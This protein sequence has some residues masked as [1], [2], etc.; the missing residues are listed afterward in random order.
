M[1]RVTPKIKSLSESLKQ[2]SEPKAVRQYA[3]ATSTLGTPADGF[4]HSAIDGRAPIVDLSKL[5]KA[6]L[7]IERLPFTGAELVEGETDD[8]YRP[9]FRDPA[10]PYDRIRYV[11]AVGYNNDSQGQRIILAEGGDYVE[12]TFYGTGLNILYT[13]LTGDDVRASINGENETGDLIPQSNTLGARNYSSNIVNPAFSGLTPGLHTVTLRHVSGTATIHGVEIINEAADLQIPASQLV[14]NG[15]KQTL[16]ALAT[17]SLDSFDLEEGTDSGQGGHVSVYMQNGQVKQAI[18]WGDSE[19][20]LGSTDHSEE[21]L[22]RRYGWR[23]FGAGRAD[24]F[25]TMVAAITTDRYFTLDDGTTTLV[26][27]D[28]QANADVSND[29]LMPVGGSGAKLEFTFVGTGFDIQNKRTDDPAFAEATYDVYVDDDQIASAVAA[30]TLFGAFDREYL[31][32]IVSGLPYG[33]HTVRIEINTNNS[34]IAIFGDLL[35]YAP[36][37]PTLPEDAVEI[38]SYYRPADYVAITTQSGGS[39]DSWAPTGVIRKMNTREFIYEGAS[40]SISSPSVANPSGAQIET[41]SSSDGVFRYT[42]F[43]TGF[44]LA[45]KTSTNRNQQIQVNLNGSAFTTANYG[46]PA[47]NATNTHSTGTIQGTAWDASTGQMSMDAST[48]AFGNFSA[49]GLP[50]DLYTIEFSQIDSANMSIEAFD[51]VTPIHSPRSDRLLN[52]D[53][54]VGSNGIQSEIS[55]PNFTKEKQHFP[56][57]VDLGSSKV[58]WQRRPMLTNPLSTNGVH[59]PLTFHNLEVGKTYRLNM[60]FYFSWTASSGAILS[61]SAICG[62]VIEGFLAVRQEMTLTNSTIQLSET[63]VFTAKGTIL[64]FSFAGLDGSR[65]VNGDTGGIRSAVVLEELP[66]HVETRQWSERDG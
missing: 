46:S 66:N 33:T 8:S 2:A 35:V 27:N 7:G 59:E 19:A 13:S 12:I 65:Y 11:G 37:K 36:K 47:T 54:L 25:S 45:Y 58:K 53:R 39:S 17:K 31:T 57:G 56:D 52:F 29:G 4:F 41:S 51:I 42:F 6:Y 18:K 21:E 24:D 15:E 48:S 49:S 60:K 44:N 26:G 34:T 38:A 14:G 5:P 16:S 28:V 22:I 23:E 30:E 40:W 10:D 50:L 55:L 32:P 9:V 64:E 1:A 61:C 62:G 3:V 20:T 43:G 63:V